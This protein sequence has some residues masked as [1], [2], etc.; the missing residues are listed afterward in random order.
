[1]KTFLLLAFCLAL[2]ALLTGCFTIESSIIRTTG[3][4]H[5]HASNHGWFLFNVVPLA[6]GNAEPDGWTPWV[7]FRNDVTMDKVQKRFMEYTNSQNCDAADLDYVAHE[8][9]MLN[10]PGL[11]LPLPIP[12]II[13]YQEIQLSGILTPLP[14]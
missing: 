3:Q 5:L 10:L 8:S 7:L 2:C 9:V 14:R 12:Y 6:C 1:M 4:E 11:N 13:T